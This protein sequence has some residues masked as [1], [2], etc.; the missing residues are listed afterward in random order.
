MDP[1]KPVIPS[2]E[3]GAGGDPTASWDPKDPFWN[4][5]SIPL[6]RLARSIHANT[7]HPILDLW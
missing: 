7:H 4:L 2:P 1:A 3:A 6:S 5:G